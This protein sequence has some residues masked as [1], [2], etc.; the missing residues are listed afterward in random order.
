MMQTKSAFF[1]L[2]TPFTLLAGLVS[3]TMLIAHGAAYLRLK[4]DHPIAEKAHSIQ[5]FASFFALIFFASAGIVLNKTCFGFTLESASGT[6]DILAKVV[7]MQFIVESDELSQ[8]FFS[9]KTIIATMIAF[10]GF[11]ISMVSGRRKPI[12]GFLGTSFSIIGVIATAGLAT[13]HFILPSILVPNHSL[14]VWDASSSRLTLFIMLISVFIF[15]PFVLGY[16]TWTYKVFSKK[17]V[18]KDLSDPQMY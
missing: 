6:Q 2:F 13:F 18:L 16:I 12:V 5:K 8:R 17:L 1:A 3:L 4:I 11:V 14:T 9:S 15:L 7:G 10:L